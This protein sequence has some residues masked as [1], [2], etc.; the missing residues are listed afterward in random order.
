MRII[1]D[2]DG[3]ELRS[4]IRQLRGRFRIIFDSDGEELGSYIRQ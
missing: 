2:S 1:Y 4:Y 3:E